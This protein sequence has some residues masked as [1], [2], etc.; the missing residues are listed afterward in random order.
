MFPFI[1]ELLV[2]TIYTR[3]DEH[4]IILNNYQNDPTKMET[5][6][7]YSYSIKTYTTGEESGGEEKNN[8]CET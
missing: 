2:I 4:Y 6:R 1:P 3:K 5:R 8:I 7:T